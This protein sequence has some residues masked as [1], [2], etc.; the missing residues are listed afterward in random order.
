MVITKEKKLTTLQRI[1][2]WNK[3]RGLLDKGFDKKL[4]TSFLI[5]EILEFNGCKGE[6]KELARQIAEDIDNE[7]ITYNLDIEYVEPDSQDIIDGLG[8]LIVF[9]TGAMAKKLKEI[10]SPHTVDDIINLIMDANDR[11]GS[12]TDAYGK[13][14]KD[15][16]FAQPKLV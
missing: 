5:E 7:Y 4:E 13:L 8:D 14:I 10:N 3:K 16:E 1:V 6:V 15:K 9:A 11:K 12:K 2:E